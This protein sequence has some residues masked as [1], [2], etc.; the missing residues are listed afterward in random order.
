MHPLIFYRPFWVRTLLAHD[1]VD[2]DDTWV[3]I[4]EKFDNSQEIINGSLGT[5]MSLFALTACNFIFH[6]SSTVRPYEYLTKLL[7]TYH[8]LSMFKS[9]ERSVRLLYFFN[10]NIFTKSPL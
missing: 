5:K 6:L 7:F 1:D 4:D 9:L 2:G 3:L 10:N 8:Y